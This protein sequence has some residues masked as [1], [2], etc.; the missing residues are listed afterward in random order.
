MIAVCAS[1]SSQLTI[2]LNAVRANYVAISSHVAPA[3]CGVV[4]KAD[5]YG[6]GASEIAKT[7]VE[8]GC[9]HFFVAHLSE[10]FLLFETVGAGNRIFI[11]NG[12]EPGCEPACA[13]WGFIPVLNSSSQITRWRTL[14]RHKGHPL[15]AAVQIDTGMSRL[16]IDVE[17]A[18]MLMAEPKLADELSL[19]L[20][21]THLSCADQTDHPVNE[22]QLTKFLGIISLADGIPASI[23]NS[24]GSFLPGFGFDMVRA[25]IG[26]F[27]GLPQ[28][29][30]RPVINLDVRVIQIRD[31]PRGTGV[32]YGHDHITSGISRLATIAMGYADGIPRSLSGKGAAFYNG[33]RL[34]MVGRISM[35]SLTIDIS[36][37]PES[38]LCE[39]DFVE[40]IGSSQSL[41]DIARDAETIPYEILVRLGSRHQRVYLNNGSTDIRPGNFQ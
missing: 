25:G 33:I 8:E 15:A 1:Y 29:Q 41:C 18:T 2:D 5:A 10:A 20:I 6:L 27:G 21:M 3:K 28:T 35:D 26:L 38:A 13:H 40:I 17:T 34:P 32:G 31:V 19:E 4:L 16:G 30:L 22:S 14:A 36:G 9:R 24:A 39:G 12:L 11:L 23:A 37:L 7:L